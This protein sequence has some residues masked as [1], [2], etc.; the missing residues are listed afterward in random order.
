MQW[1]VLT[2]LLEYFDSLYIVDNVELISQLPQYT[3]MLHLHSV[4]R[5]LVKR[6]FWIP[7]WVSK[8]TDF[9]VVSK[10]LVA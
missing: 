10:L 6:Y 5:Y 3:C 8:N 9:N 7:M 4:G 2:I 1:R